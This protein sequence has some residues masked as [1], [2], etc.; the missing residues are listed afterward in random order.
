MNSRNLFE[1]KLGRF[2]INKSIITDT[3]SLAFTVLST[4]IPIRAE[5][6]LE[7]D[8]IHYTGICHNFDILEYG[9]TPPQYEAEVNN[10][11]VKWTKLDG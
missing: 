2:K 6:M 1:R 7:D 4:V 10:N 8:C 9:C 5:Y 11:F 3:P